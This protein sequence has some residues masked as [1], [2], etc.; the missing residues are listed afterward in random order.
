MPQN[1][2]VESINA[3]HALL[4]WGP[5]PPDQQNGIISHYILKVVGIDTDERFNYSSNHNTTMIGSLHP[6]YS[7]TF[8]IAAYT[9]KVGP[10]STPVI[11]QMPSAGMIEQI[12]YI[13]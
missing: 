1:I 5:P 11:L 6:F 2:S 13:G 4:V 8:S 10:F 12:N 7:Y 3:T 9:V